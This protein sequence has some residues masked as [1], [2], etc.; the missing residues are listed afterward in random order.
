MVAD[1][2]FDST[3]SVFYILAFNSGRLSDFPWL[4]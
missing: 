1:L 2:E 4:L 3:G